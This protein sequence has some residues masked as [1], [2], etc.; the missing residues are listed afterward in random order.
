MTTK[1]EITITEND[2]VIF[3]YMYKEQTLIEKFK[4]AKSLLPGKGKHF[5]KNIC[6]AIV[7]SL[8]R[9][10]KSIIEGGN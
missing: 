2:D 9:S 5:T 10:I 4:V 7:S 3:V 1:I 8:F 6:D